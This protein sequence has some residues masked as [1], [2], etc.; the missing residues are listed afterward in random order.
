VTNLC[1][2]CPIPGPWGASGSWPPE[3]VLEE[4]TDGEDFRVAVLAGSTRLLGGDDDPARERDWQDAVVGLA[5]AVTERGGTLVAPA[6]VALVNLL[7]QV[8]LPHS[9]PHG[10]E[11][12]HARTPVEAMMTGTD[13]AAARR[14]LAPFAHR[15]TVTL[16]DAD[17]SPLPLEELPLP[18]Q[19]DG[20]LLRDD[21]HQ[22]FHPA[23]LEGVLGA[24]VIHPGG[25]M[26]EEMRALRAADLRWVAV[27]GG[28]DLADDMSL[29]AREHD[30]TGPLLKGLA[31]LEELAGA[32][33][34]GLVMEMLVDRWLDTARR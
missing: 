2:R 27:L 20:A 17:R 5:A 7:A 3:S 9:R 12:V 34:H 21:A 6:D 26:T 13:S 31:E 30:P 10:A 29:W 23:L 8:A 19:E 14:L 1:R 22:P 18:G 28:E 16:M 32:M 11:A 24:V 25:R 4:P 15:G 33:P